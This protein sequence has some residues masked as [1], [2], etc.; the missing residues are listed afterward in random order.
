MNTRINRLISALAVLLAASPALAETV[1][2]NTHPAITYTGLWDHMSST[3]YRRALNG[4]LSETRSAGAAASLTFTGG[5]YVALVHTMHSNRWKSDVFI[6]GVLE[7]T[8]TTRTVE[9]NQ[10]WQVMRIYKLSQTVSTH[11]IRVV[12]K[13][14]IDGQPSDLSWSDVDAFIVEPDVALPGATDP[15]ASYGPDSSTL[16]YGGS[17]AWVTGPNTSWM[18]SSTKGD[19]VRFTFYGNLLRWDYYAN[20]NR[21]IAEITLDGQALG[22]LDLY[23]PGET[24]TY[25]LNGLEPGMHSVTITVS[26]RKNPAATANT[27]DIREVRVGR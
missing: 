24:R 5:R 21:G 27:V 16:S 26:G 18:E 10:R 8:I 19:S 6:D 12:A 1:Y 9:V 23:G 3:T 22:D 17:W 4:T 20:P 15:F 13:G 14:A 25:R 11:T 7:E 2:D